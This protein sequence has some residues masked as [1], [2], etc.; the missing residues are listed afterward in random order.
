MQF[1]Y[2]P[3]YKEPIV[4]T[5]AEHCGVIKGYCLAHTQAAANTLKKKTI[6]KLKRFKPVSLKD[7]PL[8]VL[9]LFGIKRDKS[10]FLTPSKEVHCEKRKGKILQPQITLLV[11]SYYRPE[12]LERILS[13]IKKTV[14]IPH[15]ILI[16]LDHNDLQAY[17]YCLKKGYQCLLSNAQRGW[18]KQINMGA[19]VCDTPYFCWLY[20]DTECLQKNWLDD[21]LKVYQ[22]KFPTD[23]GLLGLN[24]GIHKEKGACIIGFTSKKFVKYLGGNLV[25]PEYC[26]YAGD[27]ELTNLSKALDLY[28]F[29]ENIEIIHHHHSIGDN[30][31]DE[32]YE[33]AEKLFYER[34]RKLYSKRIKQPVL[35]LKNTTSYDRINT[36]AIYTAITGE[37]DELVD[38]VYIDSEA[39]Y[40]CFTDKPRLYKSK[41]KVWNI[42]KIDE[43]R[44]PKNFRQEKLYKFYKVNP[45][46]I[47]V[48][49]NYD[50]TI[51]VDAN[52]VVKDFMVPLIERLEG[53][54]WGLW[55]HDQRNCIYE[56][57]KCVVELKYETGDII[58]KQMK[59]YKKQK[60]PEKNG[61]FI[62]GLIVRDHRDGK[63]NRVQ[64][65]WWSEI[66]PDEKTFRCQFSFN[67]AL[68]K[69]KVNESEIQIFGKLHGSYWKEHFGFRFHNYKIIDGVKIYAE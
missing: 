3:N 23:I 51:W 4:K 57:A 56:A 24:A 59:V 33:I 63:T 55:E 18:V 2:D 20:D 19:A 17:F 10:H 41:S 65:F 14:K 44:F 36:V 8:D 12:G 21:A 66:E 1:F 38:P 15:K 16:L 22:E 30:V 53:K 54:T 58:Y 32:S 42:I 47:P 35:R 6:R 43:N 9:H 31:K 26:H 64:D 29:E 46:K 68:W 37:K 5:F 62:T 28:Y 50:F 27:K 7:I 48:L 49:Q 34:D 52:I 39:D 25:Y 45:H 40:Y 11:T 13:S 61:I 60:Y 69:N 67:Y